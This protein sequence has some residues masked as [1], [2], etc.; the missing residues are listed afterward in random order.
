VMPNAK[1][2]VRFRPEG[3]FDRN[4]ALGLGKIYG[5]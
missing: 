2:S 1:L 4:P 5:K 3:F